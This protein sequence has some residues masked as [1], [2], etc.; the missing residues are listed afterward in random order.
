MKINR[1]MS[2]FVSIIG[3]RPVRSQPTEPIK[4]AVDEVKT[5]Y[6]INLTPE[7]RVASAHSLSSLRKIREQV[8]AAQHQTAPQAEH[9]TDV[10]DA[11]DRFSF[12]NRDNNYDETNTQASSKRSVRAAN[13]TTGMSTGPQVRWAEPAAA[14]SQQQRPPPQR[15]VVDLLRPSQKSSQQNTFSDSPVQPARV[16]PPT[17]EEDDDESAGEEDEESE[18]AAEEEEEESEEGSQGEEG[19]CV[20]EA[21]EAVGAEIPSSPSTAAVPNHGPT[22]VP[23]PTPAAATKAAT[24][25]E[26]APSSSSAQREH[27]KASLTPAAATIAQP[28]AAPPRPAP[29][30]AATEKQTTTPTH[31]EEP[32]ETP[33]WSEQARRLQQWEAELRERERR[34]L[35]YKD[36]ISRPVGAK[37]PPRSPAATTVGR[38]SDYYSSSETTADTA[39]QED[40]VYPYDRT[41]YDLPA[42][43]TRVPVSSRQPDIHI[44]NHLPP[45]AVPSPAAQWARDSWESITAGAGEEKVRFPY[46]R[47]VDYD[48]TTGYSSSSVPSVYDT[49]SATGKTPAKASQAPSRTVYQVDYSATQPALTA[50][51]TKNTTSGAS[52]E[53][54]HE[55]FA[56]VSCEFP[57]WRDSASHRASSSTQQQQPSDGDGEEVNLSGLSLQVRH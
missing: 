7:M 20:E 54:R 51:T 8:Q 10:F 12:Y 37:L 19:D 11:P 14:D 31:T 30:A 27:A 5:T 17:E 50:A 23:M 49:T 52:F 33:Q 16:Q 3:K 21:K 28:V 6:P 43:E 56:R 46:D 29:P 4:L 13:N 18:A 48:S 22:A 15:S 47:R 45:P 25:L 9:P 26:P 35:E 36:S 1:L 55:M 42:A 32:T 2:I 24:S 40:Y 38:L 57:S 39:A 41:R 44:H 34:L 53:D